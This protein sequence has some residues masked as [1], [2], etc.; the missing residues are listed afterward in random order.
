VGPHNLDDVVP[1]V[2]AGRADRHHGGAVPYVRVD[3]LDGGQVLQ[4]V[5][6][7]DAGG[8][9]R[10]D[11]LYGLLTAVTGSVPNMVTVFGV[12]ARSVTCS[13]AQSRSCSLVI[14]APGRRIDV[15]TAVDNEIPGT[16]GQ[17]NAAA[18]VDPSEVAAVQPTADQLALAA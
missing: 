18:G 16:A 8:V 14:V 3:G 13:A 4:C 12:A 6:S 10:S 15:V 11:G 1:G 17:V 9:A 2:L 7:D 5:G